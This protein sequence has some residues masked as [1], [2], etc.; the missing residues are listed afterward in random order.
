MKI[1][2]TVEFR[3]EDA[4]EIAE[5]VARSLAPDNLT[6]MHTEI[7]KKSAK[8]HISTEKITSLIATLDDLLMNA[9]VAE[10]VLEELEE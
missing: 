6:S 4:G 10:E 8:I 3:D 5:R 9:K 7:T 1:K 2:T